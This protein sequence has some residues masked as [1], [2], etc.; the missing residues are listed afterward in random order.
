MKTKAGFPILK[1]PGFAARLQQIACDPL[2]IEPWS[3][4]KYSRVPLAGRFDMKNLGG[5]Y[6]YCIRFEQDR[7][8]RPTA[9]MSDWAVREPHTASDW[10]A[11]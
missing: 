11:R 5:L 8:G 10:R 2:P 9:R 3:D 6:G 4:L 7:P 1:G